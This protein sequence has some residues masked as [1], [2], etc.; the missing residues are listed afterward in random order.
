MYCLEVSVREPFL[1]LSPFSTDN[2]AL[3]NFLSRDKLLYLRYNLRFLL[4]CWLRYMSG[5]LLYLHWFPLPPIPLQIAVIFIFCKSKGERVP[6]APP[7]PCK[8][9]KKI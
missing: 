9:L 4:I 5:V 6:T 7:P 8:I 1:S 2:S 3:C